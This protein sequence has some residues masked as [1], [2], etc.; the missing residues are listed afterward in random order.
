MSRV[1]TA[2]IRTSP[3]APAQ[4]SQF[5]NLFIKGGTL[6]GRLRSLQIMCQQPVLAST[7]VNVLFGGVTADN[8]TVFGLVDGMT[9]V[10]E[11]EERSL[12]KV[13]FELFIAG[14][15][16]VFSEGVFVIAPNGQQSIFGGRIDRYPAEVE[17]RSG[18]RK[19]EVEE[20]TW[21][22]Q[23]QPGGPGVEPYEVGWGH[24]GHHRQ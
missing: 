5:W 4:L 8:L 24:T 6:E 22:A 2:E 17:L 21:S 13:S 16:Y 20:G 15:R 12:Q 1:A 10:V 23:A 11:Q 3:G 18:T 19:S 14:E 7:N 9:D